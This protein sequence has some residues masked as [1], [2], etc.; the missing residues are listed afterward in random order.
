MTK[1]KK[2]SQSKIAKRTIKYLSIPHKPSTV[3][4]VVQEAPDSVIRAIS[5]AALNAREGDVHVPPHLKRLFCAHRRHFDYLVDRKYPIQRKRKLLV[6][7][8]GALPLVVPLIAT[9]LGSIG[10]EFISRLFRK[11]E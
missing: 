2:K 7:R 1:S 5:N 8:G 4:A 11:N 6:Q 3:R 10:G 9:V